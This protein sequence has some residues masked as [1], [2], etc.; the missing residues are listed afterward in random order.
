MQ[1]VFLPSVVAD[2]GRCQALHP[3]DG[4]L[5]KLALLVHGLPD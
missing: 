5:Q 3:T 4:A 1:E 2:N